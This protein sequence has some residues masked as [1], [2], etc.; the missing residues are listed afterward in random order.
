MNTNDTKDLICI[1]CPM[2]CRL[3]ITKN[4]NEKSGYKVTGNSCKKGVDYAIKELTNPTRV[5]TSTVRI[6]HTHLKRL[7]VK[8]N[9]AIPKKLNFACM[10]IIN[11]LLLDSP[12]NMGDILVENILNTGADLVATRS[13][14]KT[15]N[16]Q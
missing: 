4:E 3:T 10:D 6:N 2:G 1:N 14:A 15:E 11:S 16:S 13:M 12:I 9:K 8:T 7:P 5:I